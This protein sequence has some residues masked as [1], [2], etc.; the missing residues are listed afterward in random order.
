M[1]QG[2]GNREGSVGSS[3]DTDVKVYCEDKLRSLS[4]GELQTLVCVG[5]EIIVKILGGPIVH[6]GVLFCWRSGG[7]VS[8]IINFDPCEDC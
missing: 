8:R 2:I 4:E 6:V 1:P 7:K 3:G 5:E